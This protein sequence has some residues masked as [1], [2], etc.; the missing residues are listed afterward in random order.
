MLSDRQPNVH[1]LKK[2]LRTAR[3]L[4]S[5]LRIVEVGNDILHSS[6]VLDIKWN[7]LKRVARGTSKT[8]FSSYVAGK[9]GLSSTNI[10]FTHAPFWVQVWGLPFEFMDEEVGKDIGSTIGNFLEVDKRSWQSDQAKFMR[11]RVDVHL[12]MPLR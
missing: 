9:K 4:S 6:L 5:N 8:T 7:E 12:N 1:A 3:K 2:T 10:V 11:I